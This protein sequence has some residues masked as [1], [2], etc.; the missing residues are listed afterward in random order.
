V[1]VNDERG[2]VSFEHKNQSVYNRPKRYTMDLLITL[3]QNN[4]KCNGS[5]LIHMIFANPILGKALTIS[6][7][8]RLECSTQVEFFVMHALWKLN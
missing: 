7:V 4:T 1:S 6:F 2:P 3:S 5:I 8:L